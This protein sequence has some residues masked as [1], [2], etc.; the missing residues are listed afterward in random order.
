MIRL[1]NI[2]KTY[3]GVP[4]FSELSLHIRPGVRIGL[5]GANGA[6]KTTL[7]NILAGETELDEGTRIVSGKIRVGMLRQEIGGDEDETLLAS[8]LAG[9]THISRMQAA[10]EAATG[11]LDEAEREGNL[12]RVEKL[13]ALYSEAE[14]RFAGAGGY[15]IEGKAK[16]IISGLGFKEEDMERRV[17]AFSGGWRMRIYLARLLLSEPDLLL[18]DEPT[19]HLDL[20]SSIWLESFL[21]AYE[22]GLVIISHDRYFLNRM[23]DAIADIDYKKLTLY[24]YPY[25]RYI[26]EKE[27]RRALLDS[28]ANRQHKEIERQ[29]RFIE[30]FRAKNTKATVVQSRIKA[31]AKIDRITTTRESSGI[32]FKFHETGRISN[33]PVEVGQ[34]K[35]AYGEN[36]VYDR[37]DF[38]MRRGDRIAL[39]GPN[40][41]GKST[42][43]KLLSGSVPHLEGRVRIAENVSMKYFAQHQLDT[44]NPK[45]SVLEEVI[46]G[47]PFGAIPRA[48][49]ILGGFLF[50]KDD[51]DKK[52]EILSGGEKSRVALAKIALS[53]TNLLLLDEP[54]NHLDLKSR[55][56]LEKSLA[57]YGGCILF[58]SHDRA[59]IDAV[60]NK[61]VHVENGELTE[62][63]GNWEY[64]EKKRG[65]RIDRYKA[66]LPAVVN[67]AAK[68]SGPKK[69]RK[70]SRKEAARK[71]KAVNEA[72]APVKKEIA[73]IEKRISEIDKQTEA[74]NTQLSDQDTYDNPEKSR[75]L[76]K[77]LAH[78]N[79]ENGQLIAKWELLSKELEEINSAMAR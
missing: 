57:Q 9:A 73:S 33:I 74:L 15:F 36:I 62:F 70:E 37:L 41:A 78:L 13:A 68:A 76:G 10:M 19:N 51:V 47:I 44:L 43:I 12:D 24:P 54:T 50:R 16:A 77:Q 60:A 25:D 1:E 64:Y 79:K 32:G 71:R 59:F 53:P 46:S 48:R 31:L 67:E 65:E 40:G 3:G 72:V 7:L 2:T 35:V 23:V 6:G 61:I 39:V 8:V 42:L 29:E 69:S 27:K 14:E 52:V 49:T 63:L 18:L 11:R 66:P 30:R 20:E 58:I 4:L 17:G 22:G 56:A 34:V 45:N 55:Q 28:A 38:I 5:V 26:E 21:L 75:E